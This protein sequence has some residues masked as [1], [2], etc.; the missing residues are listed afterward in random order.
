MTANRDKLYK[1]KK[2][3]ETVDI[4]GENAQWIIDEHAAYQKYLRQVTAS[5]S[6]GGGKGGKGTPKA[7]KKRSPSADEADYAEALRQGTARVGPKVARVAIDR[8][9]VN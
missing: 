4:V 6:K 7:K 2:K 5:G 8:R 3:A 9:G 1:W